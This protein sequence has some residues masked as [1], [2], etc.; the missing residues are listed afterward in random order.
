V[1]LGGA[2]LS[3]L[4]EGGVKEEEAGQAMRA[5][6]IYV[7]GS[8]AIELPRPV[9]GTAVGRRSE[10]DFRAGLHWF[11]GGLRDASSDL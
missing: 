4:R 7:I 5:L 9:P 6:M 8:A 11:L 10:S 1:R 2:A 3:L